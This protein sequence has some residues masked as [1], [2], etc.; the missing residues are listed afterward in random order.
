MLKIG[1]LVTRKKYGNDIIFKVTKIEKDKVYLK[2]IELRLF[3][4]AK[5]DD[6]VECET[7][8]KKQ[9][10]NKLRNFDTS[11]YFYIPGVILHID[12]DS[13]YMDRCLE[14]YK[15]QNIKAYGYYFEP[16][17]F[18]NKIIKLIDKHKPNILVITGHDAYY[19]EKNTY[20]NS[21]YYIET[22]NEAR[23]KYNNHNDL[24]IVSG[25]CQSDYDGL[26]KAGATFASSPN[27]INVHALDPAIIASYMALLDKTKVVNIEEVLSKTEYGSAGYGG[28]I[29]NG[30]L[31]KGY[32][33]KDK[34]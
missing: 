9:I 20:K 28:L 25:A 17:E 16:S 18:K 33:R 24:L 27:H 6:L 12:T 21:K 34:N 30:M 22:V 4:D 11:K 14:Y 7:C 19:K 10:N 29:T 23:K 15:D 31:L 1:S 2:G 13:E 8:K 26:L 32:P 5:K 3:A